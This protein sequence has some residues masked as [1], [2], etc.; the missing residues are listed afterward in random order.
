MEETAGIALMLAIFLFI[1]SIIESFQ[2]RRI[3]KRLDK[4]EARDRM[5]EVEKSLNQM[6][7][8]IDMLLSKGS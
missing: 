8:R 3:Q 2:I 4:L 6:Q 1:F 5:D 7:M